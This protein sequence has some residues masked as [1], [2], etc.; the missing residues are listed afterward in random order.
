[1]LQGRKT[2]VNFLP[3]V[4]VSDVGICDMRSAGEIKPVVTFTAKYPGRCSYGDHG[5]SE[6]DMVGY[7]SHDNIQCADCLSG[8]AHAQ[9][10]QA[11][12]EAQPPCPRCFM[13]GPCDCEDD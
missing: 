7:D 2:R 4:S 1:M 9:Q 8:V 6:G 12:R 3:S 5:F 11:A 13:V 10:R